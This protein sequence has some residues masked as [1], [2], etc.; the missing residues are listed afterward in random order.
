MAGRYLD[1]LGTIFS[2]IQLG[3]GGP[4]VKGDLSTPSVQARLADDSDFCAL[5]AALFQTFGDDFELNSGAAGSGDDWLLTFSRPS[6]GMTHNLQVIWP[7][8]DPAA[9]QVLA[10]ASLVGDVLTLKWSTVAAGADK[11]VCDVTTIHFGD[12]SPIAMFAKPANADISLIRTTIKTSFDT[13]ATFSVGI[14][15]TTSKYLPT[16][17]TDL[18]ADAKTSFDYVPGEDPAGG[19]E[20]LIAT[21]AA[22][23]ASTGEARVYVFY[24]IPS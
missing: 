1:L 17:A 21:Y 12:S 22:N 20:N 6:T 16:T 18:E 11:T 9:D 2:K 19:I 4:H 8:D 7:P 13:A 10:V 15:G 5:Q 24:S 23:S 14:T 3:L